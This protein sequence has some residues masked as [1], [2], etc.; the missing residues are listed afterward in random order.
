MTISSKEDLKRL[1]D[2]KRASIVDLA[3]GEPIYPE[4]GA[5]VK[6][7]LRGEVSRDELLTEINRIYVEWSEKCA[8]SDE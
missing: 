4:S 7:Y 1:E 2:L 8:I 5:I 6:S 3:T